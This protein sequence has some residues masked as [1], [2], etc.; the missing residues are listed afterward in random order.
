MTTYELRD[1]RR[2]LESSLRG[3]PPAAP[4]RDLL[5][6]KLAQVTAEQ[7]DRRKIAEANGGV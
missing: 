3:L 7:E 5:N 2:Q 6:G 1:Y 4:V